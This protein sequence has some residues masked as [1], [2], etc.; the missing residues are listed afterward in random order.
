MPAFQKKSSPVFDN[1]RLLLLPEIVFDLKAGTASTRKARNANHR[2]AA[3]R[4]KGPR[5]K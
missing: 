2:P 1:S 3:S 5:K 4:K